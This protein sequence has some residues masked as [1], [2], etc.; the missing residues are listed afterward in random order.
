MNQQ[1]YESGKLAYQS[2][3]WLGAV[4][5]LGEAKAPG[6]A[7]GEVDHLSTLGSWLR[8]RMD[9]L[10]A[11]WDLSASSDDPAADE[12]KIFSPVKA[13]RDSSGQSS[14]KTHFDENYEAWK[15]ERSQ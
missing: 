14:Y 6:E 7:C 15:P 9:A 8:N 4:A 12:A 5:K 1:A 10:T 2:G 3:D 11:G 13:N